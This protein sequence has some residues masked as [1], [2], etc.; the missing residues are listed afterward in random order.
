[1]YS[2]CM[3][4][5]FMDRC[6]SAVDCVCIL[7]FTHTHTQTH[8][9]YCT[10]NV[11]VCACMCKP[12]PSRT[13]PSACWPLYGRVCVCLWEGGIRDKY[14]AGNARHWQLTTKLRVYRYKLKTTPIDGSVLKS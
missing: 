8:L 5:V 3:F 13:Q 4:V 14:K 6:L 9:L 2:I 12:K 10:Q 7:V 11:C 1:M